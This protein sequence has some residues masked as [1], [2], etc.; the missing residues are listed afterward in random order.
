MAEFAMETAGERG[1]GPW[2]N[3]PCGSVWEGWPTVKAII[4]LNM[5]GYI[6]EKTHR[7]QGNLVGMEE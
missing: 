2:M 7:P 5:D 1:V 4:S 3:G 6:L